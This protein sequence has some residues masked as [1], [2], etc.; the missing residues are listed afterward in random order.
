MQ[1]SATVGHIS[2]RRRTGFARVV[3]MD[4]AWVA[5]TV[6]EML[7]V[8]SVRALRSMLGCSMRTALVRLV[9]ASK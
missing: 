2:T 9:V 8:G 3:L 6:V 5:R 4:H 1:E 7:A